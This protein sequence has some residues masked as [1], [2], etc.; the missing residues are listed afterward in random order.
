[1]NKIK[2]FS[3]LFT[4]I[5]LLSS[6][7]EDYLNVEPSDYVSDKQL[8]DM[9]SLSPEALIKVMQP[10]VTGLY[11]WLTQF[12]SLELADPNH[13]DFGYSSLLLRSE[14]WG[15]DMI[16]TG[17]AYGWF[18]ADY[19]H[20]NWTYTG[21]DS[22]LTWSYLYKLIKATNDILGAIPENTTDNTLKHLRGQ[23]SAM[24][25]F[26]Y[27]NL[28]Q[29]YQF[30]YKGHEQALGVPI[31]VPGMT[32]EQLANNPRASVSKVYELI[33]K[34]YIEA[35]KLLEG[36]SSTTKTDVEKPIVAG[37]LA[38]M[39][40]C[41][42]D[43]D[44]ASKYANIARQGLSPMSAEQYN[45]NTTGFNDVNNPAWM[46]GADNTIET[47][48]VKSG[49]INLA[50]HIG[51]LSYGYAYAG[52]MYKAISKE[53]YDRMSNSDSRKNAFVGPN[54]L[55]M[56]AKWKLPP[57]ANIKFKPY[58]GNILGP[59]NA[60]DYVFMRVEEMYLIEAEAKAMNN[61]ISG[62]KSL[63]EEMVQTRDPQYKVSVSSPGDVREEIWWQRRI[64]L[65]GEGFSWFD[66]KRLK[67]PTNRSY[68]GSNHRSDARYNLPAEHGLF[69]L[70]IPERE[71]RSNK[72]IPEAANNPIAV[73]P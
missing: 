45:D 73:N 21:D 54:G 67:K 37:L 13:N 26:A 10:K 31:V 56:T 72:G 35:Y 22:F 2:Y 65:W 5:A 24:R 9:A 1:M 7:S 59:D 38:R 34:D 70:R 42:E 39:Y 36:Y 68:P 57:Y 33:E 15:Q 63:L 53:V 62:A 4:L 14:L 11:S 41:K 43:W 47:R 51:S 20:S 44:N 50:S 40:L 19:V 61:D 25:G 6:C 8:T 58:K 48:I 64:E 32:P 23:A 71:L 55:Q 29:L 66:L 27:H 69:L 49:I 28:I 3:A 16:Q 12:N 30:T 17:N 18:D 46:W 60:T 52:K